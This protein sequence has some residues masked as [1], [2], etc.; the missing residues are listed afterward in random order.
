MR[1]DEHVVIGTIFGDEP[2]NW[3]TVA[4]GL[5]DVDWLGVACGSLVLL[6]LDE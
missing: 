5:D 3:D 4:G 1:V 2:A 6:V